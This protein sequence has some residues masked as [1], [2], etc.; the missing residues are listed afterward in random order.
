M[1]TYRGILKGNT[2]I[3]EQEPDVQEG[4]EVL[5]LIQATEDEEQEIVR[6]QKAMLEKGFA[7]GKLLYKKREELY[8]RGK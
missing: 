3:L 4:T 2:V 7:M 1:K 5:V 8:E 6:R